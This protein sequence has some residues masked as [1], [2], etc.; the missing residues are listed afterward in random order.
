MKALKSVCISDKGL[1]RFG[2]DDQEWKELESVTKILKPFEKASQSLCGDKNMTMGLA[3]PAYNYV[4]DRLEDRQHKVDITTK[5]AILNALQSL[6]WYYSE[7]TNPTYAVCML[8][9][10]RIKDVYF[11]RHRWDDASKRW[12]MESFRTIYDEY[13]ERYPP[14]QSIGPFRPTHSDYQSSDSEND[15]GLGFLGV[16]V[17]ENDSTVNEMSEYLNERRISSQNPYEWWYNNKGKYRV[18]YRMVLDFQ[19]IPATSAPAERLF[20]RANR[21]ATK[22]R[23]NLGDESV[24]VT[25]LVGSWTVNCEQLN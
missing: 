25:S 23:G 21:I 4:M 22:S 20:S 15:E 7:T 10:P 5:L 11:E 16:P 12:A 14:Q 2:L 13:K 1:H 19:A 3:V 24:Q 9:D 6:M 8:L 17:V 18:L